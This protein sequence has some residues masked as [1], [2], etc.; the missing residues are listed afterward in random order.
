MALHCYGEN[1]FTFLLFKALSVEGRFQQ[2]LLE[3][4]QPFER[5]QNP[6]KDMDNIEPHIWLFPNFGRRYGFGEPDA[7][8]LWGD[9][10]FWF[11]VETCVHLANAR[12]AMKDSL[13]QLARFHFFRE[14]LENVK[15]RP[16]PPPH[17][18]ICGLTVSK[19]PGREE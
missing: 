17:L 11:E 3:G 2:F 14:A 18:A 6:F 7:L 10:S 4:L 19:Q 1:S 8:V 9:H 12:P 5:Q 15:E 13:L 16:G